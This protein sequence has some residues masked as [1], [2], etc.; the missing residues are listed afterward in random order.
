MFTALKVW[1]SSV[2]GGPDDEN[3]D[4]HSHHPVSVVSPFRDN[5]RSHKS[6]V[7]FEH[8]KHKGVL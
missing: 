8:R 2:E 6:R 3:I 4:P 1:R 5:N 7:P